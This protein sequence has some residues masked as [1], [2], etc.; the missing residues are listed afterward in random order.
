MEAVPYTIFRLGPGYITECYP[1][2]DACISKEILDDN[3]VIGPKYYAEMGVI[4]SLKNYDND[5][6]ARSRNEKLHEHFKSDLLVLAEKYCNSSAYTLLASISNGS[7]EQKK[8]MLLAAENGNLAGMVA[9]GQLLIL[10]GERETGIRWILRGADRK[11]V[12]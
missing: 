11:S 6:F 2:D 9:Y 7:V 4:D 10:E 8:Y 5:F 3:G 1:I 12:V